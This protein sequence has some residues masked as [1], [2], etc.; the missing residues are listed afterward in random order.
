MSGQ[1]AAKFSEFKSAGEFDL[2]E[3][4]VGAE[5]TN[6]INV[7]MELLTCR[8][9]ELE[10]VT[11]LKAYLCDAAD[12]HGGVTAT[13]PDGG[14]AIGTNGDILASLVTNKFWELTADSDGTIDLNITHS[15]VHSYFLIV[16]TPTGRLIASP[17]IS[18][19]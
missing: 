3:F 1:R 15:G 16:V 18:F 14:V 10:E 8:A 13:V 17:V 2:I 6:V 11:S 19:T 12:G 5:N 7:A 4:T 9:G